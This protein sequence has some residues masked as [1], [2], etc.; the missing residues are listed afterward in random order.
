MSG[1]AFRTLGGEGPDV[2]LVHGFGSD[3]LSWLG[4]LPVLMPFAKVHTLDLPG[5]GDS[6]ISA[7]GDGS[8]RHLAS[9][10]TGTLTACGIERA[11]F[12]GHSLGGALAV[13]IARDDP[14]RVASLSLVAPVGL[15]TALDAEF[16]LRYPQLTDAGE[17]LAL[18]HRLVTKPIFINK[19]TVQ[20]AL[21]QLDRPNVREAQMLIGKQ[22]V[23]HENELMAAALSIPA[24]DIPR[25]TIWGEA[26]TI[27]PIDRGKLSSFG[28]DVLAITDAGHLPHIESARLVNERLTAFLQPLTAT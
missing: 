22:L 26:D 7:L 13:L 19:M 4:N 25:L 11:H 2:V 24:L 28:G 21:A 14:A 6:D 17:A 9:I 27:N 12:V 23:R 20:R 1:I 18:L 10:V 5:H 3:R 8:P 16:P 15:G